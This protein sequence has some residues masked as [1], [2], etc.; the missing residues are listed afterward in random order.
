VEQRHARG[1]DAEHAAADRAE[2]AAALAHEPRPDLARAEARRCVTLAARGATGIA[3]L[4][5][6]RAPEAGERLPTMEEGD[7]RDA[8]VVLAERKPRRP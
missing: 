8:G 3:T 1:V 4:G 2:R 6:G 7:V 5:L